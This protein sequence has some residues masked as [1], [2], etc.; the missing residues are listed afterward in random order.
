VG[1]RGYYVYPRPDG[2]LWRTDGTNPPVQLA[3]PTEPRVTLPWAASPD[4]QVVAYVSGTGVWDF[5]PADSP[6]ALALWLVNGDGSNRRKVL[7]LL[8]ARGVD[9]T[10]MGDDSD[11]ILAVSNYQEL[12]WSPDGT[13]LAFVSAHEDQVDLYT[14]GRD[15]GP[16]TRLT[17]TP[18]LEQGPRWSPN[19]ALLAC[20][21]TQGFGTGAGWDGAG[22]VVGAA[23]GGAAVQEIPDFTLPQGTTADYLGDLIWVDPALLVVHPQGVQVGSAALVQ[24]PIGG[25]PAATIIGAQSG[26]FPSVQWSAAARTLA[27]AVAAAD[28]IEPTPEAGE[29]AAGLWTWTPAPLPAAPVSTVPASLLAWNPQGTLL[30]YSTEPGGAQQGTWIWNRTTG[31]ETRVSPDPVETLRWSPDGS[32]LAADAT[33]FSADGTLLTTL[34][35]LNVVPDAWGQAGLFFFTRDSLDAE[36]Y[37]D[38]LWL[39]DGSDVRALDA[40][41][42]VAP[43]ID[44]GLVP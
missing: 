44:T 2:S 12:A 21:T 40:K 14:L 8:P 29:P 41:L 15:G 32:R 31:Q 19:S 23:V 13:R 16:P 9:L 35:G 38:R 42:D 11:L 18:A 5:S 34:P 17:H 4:G 20:K 3:L 39:W 6:V 36:S 10:P 1:A 24:V 22:V 43:F 37:S 26:G 28:P 30:A 7:D 33:I 27:V 25:G